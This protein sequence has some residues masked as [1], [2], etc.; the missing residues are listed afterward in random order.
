MRS[1]ETI[2]EIRKIRKEIS[3]KF[4]FDPKRLVAFY[5]EKQKTRITARKPLK[6][7]SSEPV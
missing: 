4:G 3:R 6:Q 7:S 1:N 5:K 2:N